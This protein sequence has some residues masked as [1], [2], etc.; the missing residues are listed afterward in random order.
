LSVVVFVDVIEDAGKF[1]SLKTHETAKWLIK[2]SRIYDRWEEWKIREV[3]MINSGK[4]IPCAFISTLNPLT[5]PAV[6]GYWTPRG[7][8]C[9][10][11]GGVGGTNSGST[12]HSC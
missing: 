4:V 6:A 8:W 3:K 2:L 5:T 9:C 12:S 11:A 1:F 10:G 7:S